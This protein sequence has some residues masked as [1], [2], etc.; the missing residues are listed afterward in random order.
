MLKIAPSVQT[1]Q[2]IVRENPI[3]K[4][5]AAR[6]FRQEIHRFPRLPRKIESHAELTELIRQGQGF[7][8]NNRDDQKKLHKANCESLEVMSTSRYEKLFFED[9]DQATDWLHRNSRRNSGLSGEDRAG[10]NNQ[11]RNSFRRRRN[12]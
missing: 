7:V 6:R 1:G 8:L 2:V 9:V 3:A 10:S 11:T 5:R 4:S 12:S